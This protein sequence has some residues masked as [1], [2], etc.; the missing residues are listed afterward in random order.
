MSQH[1][2]P[3]TDAVSDAAPATSGSRRTQFVLGAFCLAMTAAFAFLALDAPSPVRGFPLTTITPLEQ[4]PAK[5]QDLL[6]Q[7]DQPLSGERW[8]GIVIHH[9][10]D[11]FGTPESIHRQ[12]LSW[13]Y[14][15][16]GYHFLI[17]NGNGL[18]DGEVHVGY[19]W[20]GQLPGAHVVGTAGKV[21]NEHSIGICLVGNGD[22]RAFTER[23][24][25]HLVRLVQRLQREL[26]IPRE[27]VLL[28]RDIASD[29]SS[30]GSLFPI[31]EFQSQLL[32]VPR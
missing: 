16:L 18:G 32:D 30:P 6:F 2:K 14:Q 17:G 3:T 24:I 15:G 20:T 23:Q 25:Q 13:G 29:V 26:N 7:L 31:A 9:L 21:H 8:R 11:P 4:S 19:R 1:T 28:H 22:S 5:A 10:G 12:H 27:H